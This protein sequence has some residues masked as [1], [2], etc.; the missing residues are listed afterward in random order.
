MMATVRRTGAALLVS[1]L[2]LGGSFAASAPPA[3]A[4]PLLALDWNVNAKTTLKKLNM[5]VTVP[6][7]KF[8]GVIDLGTGNLAGFLI[9]PPAQTRIDLLGLLPVV[10]ATFQIAPAFVS[11]HVDLAT[12]QVTTTS[13]FDIKVTK[14]TA[15]GI[16]GNLVGNQ[17]TTSKPVTVNIGGTADLVNGS[18]F[19]GTY[20]IPPLKTCGLLTPALSAAM[21]GPGNTFTGTFTPPPAA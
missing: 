12:L 17:C 14:V 11:G 15:G 19:T 1:M 9:L 20:E 7:G 5:E 4:D 2:A 13:S 10:D 18:T 21:S 3:S 16:T 6:Q 8:Y